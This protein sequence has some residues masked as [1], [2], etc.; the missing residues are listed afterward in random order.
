VEK[1]LAKLVISLG[2]ILTLLAVTG[3]T[4]LVYS[5][6]AATPASPNSTLT[7]QQQDP[8]NSPISYISSQA[9]FESA[10]VALNFLD[11]SIGLANH[12]DCYTCHS[13]TPSVSSALINSEINQ[14]IWM[15][16]H[17]EVDMECA[18]CHTQ[19]VGGLFGHFGG[20]D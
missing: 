11:E 7:G 8:Q 19:R 12:A 6:F 3:G 10:Q 20:D 15:Q 2:I 17:I 9:Y 1:F 4:D 13:G 14:V 16:R 18:G 5:A